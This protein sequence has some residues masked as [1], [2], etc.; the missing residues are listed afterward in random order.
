MSNNLT[1]KKY[2]KC[3]FLVAAC[4]SNA[5]YPTLDMDL[6]HYTINYLQ[7]LEVPMEKTY[8]LANNP[9]VY[10]WASKIKDLHPLIIQKENWKE[11]YLEAME[12]IRAELP[13]HDM[14]I[15]PVSRPV[16]ESDLLDLMISQ[17]RTEKDVMFYTAATLIQ[18]GLGDCWVFAPD[19]T[20]SI[21]GFRHDS[22]PTK[23]IF[24]TTRDYM[25]FHN[26]ECGQYQIGCPYQFNSKVLDVAVR[27]GFKL[28]AWNAPCPQEA[29]RRVEIKV[30]NNTPSN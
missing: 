5:Q 20:Y 30:D 12:S 1:N 21:I 17:V 7:S 15:L 11:G 4:F 14:F 6:V 9:Q 10:A 24:E 13:D 16:R 27:E 19:D 26:A 2:E 18:K 28:S 25:V 8:L 22:A 23:Q 29:P 3:V